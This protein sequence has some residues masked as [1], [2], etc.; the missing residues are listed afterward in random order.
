MVDLWHCN[1]HKEPTCMPPDNP[2][3]KYHPTLDVFSKV[4]GVSTECAEQAFKW[5]GKFKLVTRKMT[6]YKNCLFIWKIID[7]HN[8][9]VE[10]SLKTLIVH[11]KKPCMHVMAIIIILCQL[12]VH[13]YNQSITCLKFYSIHNKVYCYY[14][15]NYFM[16]LI[17]YYYYNLNFCLFYY[18]PLLVCHIIIII[19]A[20]TLTLTTY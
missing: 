20:P 19:I 17:S 8:K 1:K 16:W 3:C 12:Y 6:R 13:N 15:S 9:R 7:E 10:H 5:L 2:Q 14:Y 18:T 11:C 4:H